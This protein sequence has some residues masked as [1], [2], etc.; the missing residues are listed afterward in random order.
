MLSS[1]PVSP[2]QT[3]SPTHP[4][5]YENTPPSTH[6]LL[7]HYP[8]IFLCWGIEPSK[9]QG[10]SLPLMPDK[11]ILCYICSWSHGSL[12]VYSWVHGLVP[13]N[14]GEGVWFVAIVFPVGLQTPLIPSVL[15]LTP[16]LGFLCSIAEA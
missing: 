4:R 10:P 5:F 2:Q 8:S 9:D 6:P 15:F 12:H 3:P 11:A 13:G 1:F 14:S 7:P 16:P